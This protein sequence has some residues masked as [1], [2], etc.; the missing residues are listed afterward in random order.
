MSASLLHRSKKSISEDLIEAREALGLSRTEAA[1]QCGMTEDFVAYFE[2][3]APKSVSAD[4][5][6]RNRLRDYCKLLGVNPKDATNRYRL[7]REVRKVV[8]AC[9]S[10]LCSRK[11]PLTAVPSSRM[12]VTPKIIKAVLML[13]VVVGIGAYFV[14]AAQRLTAPPQVTVSSPRDGLVTFDRSLVV[15]GRTEREV[16]LLING[17][18]VNIDGEGN[19]SDKLDLHDGLNVIEVV[20]TKKHGKETKVTRRIIVEPRERPTAVL[21]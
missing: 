8:P 2:G 18:P 4:I 3:E 10:A 11:H 21:D 19:F 20:A 13:L 12:L 14:G 17:K 9:R 16:S 6:T 1:R 7:E 15:A 5:Y